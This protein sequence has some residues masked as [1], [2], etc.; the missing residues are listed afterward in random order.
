MSRWKQAEIGKAVLAAFNGLLD[1]NGL[2]DEAHRR[3]ERIYRLGQPDP[4]DH[5]PEFHDRL[6]AALASQ[7]LQVCSDHPALGWLVGPFR[8]HGW[9]LSGP[10]RSWSWASWT[11]QRSRF[12]V[13]PRVAPVLVPA[14]VQLPVPPLQP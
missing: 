2:G 11:R 13:S 4:W 1:M 10:S 8:M 6:V 3:A 9:R 12:R 7:G 14:L 5:I